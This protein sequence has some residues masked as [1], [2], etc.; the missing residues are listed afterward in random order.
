MVDKIVWKI[1]DDVWEII[2]DIEE[3]KVL[4]CF[5]VVLLLFD[6]G[7]E[8]FDYCKIF[9]VCIVF[10]GSYLFLGCDKG[11]IVVDGV[12]GI[13]IVCVEDIESIIL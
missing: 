1:F 10:D 4:R 9:F 8:L 3:R 11:L 7:K 5:K 13:I 6:F 2:E 12:L